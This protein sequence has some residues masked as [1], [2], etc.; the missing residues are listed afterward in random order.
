MSLTADWAHFPRLSRHK[1][2]VVQ[3]MD[4]GLG[5]HALVNLSSCPP[6]QYVP[7]LEQFEKLLLRQQMSASEA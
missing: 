4:Q 2:E 7:Q 3:H 6:D 1:W 5:D